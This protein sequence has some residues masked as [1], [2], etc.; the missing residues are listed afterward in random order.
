MKLK[1]YLTKQKW[2]TK[3]MA[4]LLL[5]ALPLS[6]CSKSPSAPSDGKDIN[7]ENVH[8]ESGEKEIVI[9]LDAENEYLTRAAEKYMEAHSDVEITLNIIDTQNNRDKYTQAVS[10][11][12]MSGKGADI[13]DATFLSYFKLAD[14]DM[15]VDLNDYIG[16]ELNNEKYYSSLM[17]SLLYNGK[18]YTIP[19]SFNFSGYQI[20]Q[21]VADEYDI[22]IPEGNLK[23]S[24]LLHF[25]EQLPK[26]GSVML[27]DGGGMGMNDVMLTSQLIGQQFSEFVDMSGK[28]ANF[29]NE[30]FYSI[31]E[32]VKKI[33][34]NQQ[35]YTQKAE[36]NNEINYSIT[37]KSLIK[38][39]LLYTPAMSND[40][41]MAYKDI[42]LLTNDEG[43]T[44]FSSA[45]FLPIISE[46]SKNKELAADFILFLLSDEMQSMPE[47]LFC[48]VNQDA[49]REV[50]LLV[51]EDSKAGGWLPDNFTEETLDV[52]I[53][54]FAKLA[55]SL[56]IFE[57]Q[58]RF[59]NS[60]INNE[61]DVLYQGSETPEQAAANLQ[62]SVQSYL[63]E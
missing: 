11:E 51:Y 21:A 40:G 41:T 46:N 30:E 6:G 20:D 22:N 13:Y 54:T 26:D 5:M 53:D 35:L 8:T 57:K 23:I 47:L 2:I 4:L 56:G 31:L 9:S 15:L 58:E 60:L 27:F 19:L 16:Q 38:Q 43:N 24:D 61:L 59:V 28:T 37:K 7:A 18:R 36:M 55:D 32:A 52:N 10:T 50:S 14:S 63:N 48:P 33:V 3:S 39:F 34:D 12:I 45:S 29:E 62:A 42:I 49:V 25:S 44:T 17:D 1:H